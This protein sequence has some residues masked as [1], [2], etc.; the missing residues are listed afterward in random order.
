MQYKV[1]RK[2]FVPFVCVS[3]LFMG[4]FS[5]KDWFPVML[6]HRIVE[7]TLIW[8]FQNAEY[9]SEYQNIRVTLLNKWLHSC[10]WM[11]YVDFLL[12]QEGR[13]KLS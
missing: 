9:V 11:L 10:D 1:P 3:F 13:M 2:Y 4:M 6:F 5:Q 12:K 8:L 7:I